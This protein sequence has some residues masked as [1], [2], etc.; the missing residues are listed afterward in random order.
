MIKRPVLFLANADLPDIT[1]CY[2]PVQNTG[3]GMGQFY[4]II[5]F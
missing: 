1:G 4:E 3:N 2:R 5:A